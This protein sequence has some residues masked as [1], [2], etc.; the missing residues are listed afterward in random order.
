MFDPWQHWALISQVADLD[1]ESGHFALQP[2]DVH[3]ENS[4]FAVIV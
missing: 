3:L 4:K 1:F 2:T